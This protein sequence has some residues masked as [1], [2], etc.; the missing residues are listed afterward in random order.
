MK[1]SVEQVNVLERRLNISVPAASIDQEFQ[2]RVQKAAQTARIDGFRPGKVPMEVIKKRFG[3]AIHQEAVGEALQQNFYAALQQEKLNPA[4][5]PK[6]ELVKAEQGQ[7]LEFVATFEVMPEITEVKGLDK[8]TVEKPVAEVTDQDLANMLETLRK[9]Q[10]S[11]ETVSRAAKDDD[12][13]NIDFEGLMDDK[14]FQGGSGSNVPL[15]LGSK[16]MIDGFE[17]GLV[18][19]KAGETRELNLQFP[20][21]YHAKELAAKPVVFRVKVNEISEPVLAEL[22]DEF[23]AKFGVADLATLKKE[24][25]SNMERELEFNLKNR[26]KN[27]VMDG[28]LANNPLDVPAAMIQEEIGRLKQQAMAQFGFQPKK[29]QKLPELPDDLFIEQAKR[30]LALGLLLNKVM[31]ANGIKAD[32]ERIKALAEKMASVYQNPEEVVKH[33]YQDKRQYAEIEQIVLE[34]QIVEKILESAT[35]TEKSVAFSDVIQNK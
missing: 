11:W 32:A 20:A 9:Q 12:R 30:R 29:G 14:P 13:V 22:N 2:K 3:V 4:G 5:M 24:V 26:V 28:L 21:D 25:R 19:V 8:I 34:E 1:V 31:S 10:A 17:A 33:Y 27:Q 7:D 23:A 15:V 35:V 6:I 18:G 16:R